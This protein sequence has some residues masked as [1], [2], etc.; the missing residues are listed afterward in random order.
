MDVIQA[1]TLILTC[2]FLGPNARRAEPLAAN[3]LGGLRE[4]GPA[5][6]NAIRQIGLAPR[7]AAQL[8][9]PNRRLPSRVAL[10]GF[11]VAPEVGGPPGWANIG[12]GARAYYIFN[13]IVVALRRPRGAPITCKS[14]ACDGERQ[15]RRLDSVGLP[16]APSGSGSNRRCSP[17]TSGRSRPSPERA[18]PEFGAANHQ[19]NKL[20]P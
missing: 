5:R 10:L 6:P 20:R 14:V 4:G 16:A 1:R 7:R 3:S 9:H 11:C 19:L 12:L 13:S 2:L 8:S 15:A 18:A 17:Q